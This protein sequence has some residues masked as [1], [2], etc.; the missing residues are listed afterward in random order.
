MKYH[1]YSNVSLSILVGTT[2]CTNPN[3]KLRNDETSL[4]PSLIGSLSP[5]IIG[6]GPWFFCSL[7]LIPVSLLFL[8]FILLARTKTALPTN[9]A[10]AFQGQA[11]GC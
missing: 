6:G 11:S 3:C 10:A 1:F 5:S 2:S 9:A 8:R 4:R 7:S